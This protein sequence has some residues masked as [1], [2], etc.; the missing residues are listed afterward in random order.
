MSFWEKYLEQGIGITHVTIQDVIMILVALGLMYLAIGKKFE[1]LLLLPLAFGMLIANIPLAGLSV[2]HFR[3]VPMLDAL[4]HQM[5]TE[6]GE[7]ITQQIPGLMNILYSGIKYVVYPPLVFLCIGT[8]T[9]FGP[10]IANPKLAIIGVAAQ[11]G[12]YVAFGLALL[13]GLVFGGLIPG[14][15]GFSFHEAAAIGIIGGADGPTA[16][17]TSSRLA[18]ELLSSISI[19]AFS[20]MALVPFIQPPIMK[21]LT[22]DKERL[23]V[24]PEPKKVTQRQKIIFPIA[25]AIVILF[26]VPSAGVL[27]GPLMLGNLLRESGVTKRFMTTLQEPL[28]NV[29]TI[30]VGLTIGASAKAEFF[31][32]FKTLLIIALGL[33][34]FVFGTTGGVLVAKLMCWITRGK[35]NPLI[36]NAGVSAMPMAARIS[37]KI[38]QRYDPQNYLLMHAMGPL[39]AGVI[40]SSVAAGIFLS[41]FG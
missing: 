25:M 19:A 2:Y 40:G 23:I 8:M 14:F 30:A 32:T 17:Y 28:L 5:F 12:I 24:M 29:L 38:G 36:G 20:Y 37:Q 13:T 6:A 4:G 15:E 26:L 39:V 31:L 21:L 35:V 16:V 11:F 34:A 41:F 22:N 7:L 9:D 1:P 3:E 27:A 33:I 18:P 10:L